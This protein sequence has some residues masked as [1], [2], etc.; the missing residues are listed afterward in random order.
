MKCAKTDQIE[1]GDERTKHKNAG[2]NMPPVCPTLIM[3]EKKRC[4]CM[5]LQRK[6]VY[7]SSSTSSTS[8]TSSSKIF[9]IIR[10]HSSSMPAAP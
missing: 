6:D 4:D 2:H 7:S 3:K 8:S 10:L 5:V 1:G 9:I